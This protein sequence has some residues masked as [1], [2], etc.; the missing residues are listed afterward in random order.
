MTRQRWTESLRVSAPTWTASAV[1]ESRRLEA[2]ARALMA[3]AVGSSRSM[4]AHWARSP[5][6]LQTSPRSIGSTG[7]ASGSVGEPSPWLVTSVPEDEQ[8]CARW[9]VELVPIDIADTIDD[10]RRAD[11]EQVGAVAVRSPEPRHSS[12][13]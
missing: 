4:R 11:P 5:P 6:Q 7:R 3:A 9:C 2:L 10:Y 1:R 13:R 8:L 12:L